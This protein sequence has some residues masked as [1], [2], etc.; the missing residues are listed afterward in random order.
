[1]PIT[2]MWGWYQGVYTLQ[3]HQ[4]AHSKYMRLSVYQLYLNK[5]IK[6]KLVE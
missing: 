1:M 6:K 3:T 5:A 2:L 4:I